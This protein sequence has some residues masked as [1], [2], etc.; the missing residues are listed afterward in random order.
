MEKSRKEDWFKTFSWTSLI[1][2]TGLVI[3]ML[4]GYIWLMEF[5]GRSYAMVCAAIATSSLVLTMM[6]I[7]DPPTTLDRKAMVR[8]PALFYRLRHVPVMFLRPASDLSTARLRQCVSRKEFLFFAGTG[9][10]F[11]SG[12]LMYTAYTPFLKDSGVTDSEVFLA[13]TVLHMS[14]VIFLP[15]NQRIV[16][17]GGEEA[18]SRLAYVP[19]ISGIVLAIVAA[20]LVAG[21]HGSVL[22]ISL[23]AFIAAEI[24]FTIWSTTTTASLLRIIPGGHE[25]SILGINSAIVGAGLLIGSIAAGEVSGAF[26]YVV[27]FSLAIVFAI[28]SFVMVSRFFRKA[29]LIVKVA[30]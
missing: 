21:N 15:F 25:G 26:G 8:W 12:S 20:S 14:K 4:A 23:F 9:L 7:K 11:L 24:G 6:F 10:F 18:M 22:M 28:A 2:S 29:L 27:T 5:D 13:Y 30:A 16:A 3:A 19:R 1:G 17:R